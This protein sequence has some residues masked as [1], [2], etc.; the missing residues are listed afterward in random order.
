ML[1]PGSSRKRVHERCSNLQDDTVEEVQLEP[2]RGQR[3]PGAQCRDRATRR[4]MLRYTTTQ[5]DSPSG[6]AITG[7][8]HIQR[9]RND[10]P[11]RKLH[12][13]WRWKPYALDFLHS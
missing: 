6:Q 8:T 11:A 9:N 2:T 3:P 7:I 13:R 10:Y 12:T 1:G 4:H 5:A